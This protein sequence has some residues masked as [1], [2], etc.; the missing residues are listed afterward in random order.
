MRTDLACFEMGLILGCPRQQG[1]G[2]NI[3]LCCN[4]QGVLD[5]ITTCLPPTTPSHLTPLQHVEISRGTPRFAN[6]K[7]QSIH[8]QELLALRQPYHILSVLSV[9]GLVLDSAIDSQ[10]A[11]D[12]MIKVL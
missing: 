12:I 7:D 9:Y 4:L 10:H 6:W 11:T 1:A 2:L 8:F 3:M 5:L